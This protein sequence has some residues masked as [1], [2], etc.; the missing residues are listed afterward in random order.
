MEIRK[1]KLKNGDIVVSNGGEYV[2][3]NDIELYLM[4]KEKEEKDFIEANKNNTD[5]F[6]KE[7]VEK[8]RELIRFIERTLKEFHI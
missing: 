3:I 2:H 8:S 6:V 5:S 4:T 7:R 1:F